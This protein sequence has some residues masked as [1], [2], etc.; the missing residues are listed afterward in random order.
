VAP[1]EE[2]MPRIRHE[3]EHAMREGIDPRRWQRLRKEDN[4]SRSNLR[5]SPTTSRD[6]VIGKVESGDVLQVWDQEDERWLL[7]RT[8]DGVVGFVHRSQIDF[9]DPPPP[10]RG[11]NDEG[12][13]RVPQRPKHHPF[14]VTLP[15]KPGYVLNPYTNA[16]VDVRGLQAGT[17][18]RD[19]HDPVANRAFRV[20]LDGSPV[21]A[22]IVEDE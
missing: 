13:K 5:S 4:G 22:V 1:D 16:V 21:R 14:A 10:R 12:E 6:N 2:G 7:V 15:G 17:L 8:G 9:S 3:S 19:P 18:V 11:D 20:P